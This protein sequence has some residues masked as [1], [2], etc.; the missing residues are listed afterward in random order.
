MATAV[1]EWFE[2]RIR[3]GHNRGGSKDGDWPLVKNG[4]LCCTRPTGSVLSLHDLFA[5]PP[6]RSEPCR[7]VLVAFHVIHRLDVICWIG[8]REW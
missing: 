3:L 6:L 2:V 1:A 7:L 8:N 4:I 5:K